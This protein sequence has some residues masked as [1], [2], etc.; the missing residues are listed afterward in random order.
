M[1]NQSLELRISALES[2]LENLERRFVDALR[3]DAMSL[4]ELELKVERLEARLKDLDHLK[5]VAFAA[6]DKVCP[7]DKA[8]LDDIDDAVEMAAHR[9]YLSIRPPAEDRET[10]S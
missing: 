4:A 1:D 7:Y 8:R 10:R 3:M 5:R 6:Y 2:R 9:I